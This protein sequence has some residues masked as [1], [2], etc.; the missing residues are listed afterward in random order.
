MFQAFSYLCFIPDIP[1]L[2]NTL[3][4]DIDQTN[5]GASGWKAYYHGYDLTQ[6]AHRPEVSFFVLFAV[7]NYHLSTHSGWGESQS[8]G[9]GSCV[10]AHR[11]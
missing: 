7:R 3:S 2:D 1:F 9:T 4:Y 8:K 10:R 5:C 6:V 11:V